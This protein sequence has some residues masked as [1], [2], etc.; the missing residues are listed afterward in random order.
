[1]PE[2]ERARL[3][4]KYLKELRERK[5]I[6]RRI[7]SARK[8]QAVHRALGEMVDTL[9]GTTETE[10]AFISKLDAET[11]LN[12]ARLE[13]VLESEIPEAETPVS[14]PKSSPQPPDPPE[15]TIGRLM[16]A[17]PPDEDA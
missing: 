12:E 8:T 17:N 1:M 11:A 4:E 13:I 7:A 14:D 5:K 6:R 2:E 9:A 3:K 10:D 16:K 15:K